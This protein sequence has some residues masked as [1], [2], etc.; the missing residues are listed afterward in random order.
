MISPQLA[1]GERIWRRAIAR[2]PRLAALSIYLGFSALI[3]A[4][5][6]A[7]HFT[8]IYLGRGIDQAFFIWCL[9]WWPYAIAHHLNPFI[10]KLIFAPTGFNLTWSTS[11]PLLSLLALPL[12]ATVGPITAFNL[13]SVACPALAAWTAFLLCHSLTERFGPAL[14]G[15]Y[16]FGFSSY[17]LAQIFGGHLSLLAAFLVP[18]AVHLALARLRGRIGRRAFTL[19][20]LAL[21]TAQF[22]IAT[23]I[24]ATMTIFGAL[25]LAAAWAMGERDLRRRIAELA[26]PILLAYLGM[27]ILVSPYLY[28]LFAG[29]RTTP[30]YSP[31]WHST[32]LLNFLVPTRTVALG[33]AIGLFRR[34]SAGFTSDAAE[35]AAYV[36]LPLLALAA[37]FTLERRR[38]LEARLLGLMLMII[39]VAAMG[40]RLHVAGQSYFKLPWSL[41]HRAPLIDQALPLRFTVYLFLT[42]AVIAARW[43]AAPP[44]SGLTRATV[45]ALVFVSLFP[46]PSA[47]VWAEPDSVAPPP[48]FFTA[49]TY[50]H[51]LAPGEIVAT[52]PYAWGEA[53]VCMLWQALSGMYFRLAG[54]YPPLSPGSFLRWPIVRSANQLATIPDPADQWKAFAASHQVTAVLR[55][56]NP[57]PSEFPSI[58]PIVAALAASDAP[59]VATG[60]ITLYR[61]PP[62]ALAPYR[63][64][65]WTRMEALADAQRF[66]A[67]L[68]A[69]QSYLASGADPAG[70]AP[71]S[72]VKLGRLPA[73]WLPMPARATDYQLYMRMEPDGFITVGLLGSRAALRPLIDRYSAYA[74]R[75]HFPSRSPANGRSSLAAELH[76]HQLMMSFDREGLARAAALALTEPP[77]LALDPNL[78]RNKPTPAIDAKL[79]AA[80][81]SR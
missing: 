11:I 73:A 59:V 26:A 32:D 60:G 69:A 61:V 29:F 63:G 48:G 5:A 39:A 4:R 75:I 1:E 47:R 2:R 67:L 8:T 46:N 45:G 66:A 33:S 58:D 38:T 43:L 81:T 56:D 41:L 57:L 52:L 40:P 80:M 68:I 20:L 18:L 54:G 36:G 3:F 7:P 51:Y 27:A 34:V 30:I 23:E 42:L 79:S 35:Q 16:I 64:L 13:L 76:Y 72:A 9:V 62:A 24:L 6:A 50:R 71:E 31:S 55:G 77:R 74:R 70:L 17:M 14:L 49:E 53:D 15:G 37:W 19:E 65:D 78:T 21:A 22:L 12:T 28:Y 44:R 10:S 25:A